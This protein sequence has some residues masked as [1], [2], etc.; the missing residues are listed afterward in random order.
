MAEQR[1]SGLLSQGTGLD[2]FINR[3]KQAY[4]QQGAL[5]AIAQAGGGLLDLLQLGGT[6]AVNEAL[7]ILYGPEEAKRRRLEI[8]Y[9]ER[10]ATAR[11]MADVV[12]RS[13]GRLPPV[14]RQ[15][16]QAMP[17]PAPTG[18]V[19][20][21]VEQRVAADRAERAELARLGQVVTAAAPIDRTDGKT[22][23]EVYMQEAA[24]LREAE[25]Q[26]E[27]AALKQKIDRDNATGTPNIMPYVLAGDNQAQNARERSFL[28]RMAQSGLLSTLQG[29]ARAERQYG[30]GPLAAF[31][32]SALDVQ[33]ARSAAEQE[34]AK[35]QSEGADRQAKILAEQIKK[36]GPSKLTG[37]I[38]KRLTSFRNNSEALNTINRYLTILTSG[39]TGGI[40]GKMDSG[41]D[42][43][44]S[45]VG[46]GSGSQASKAEAA[47]SLLLSTI[48]SLKQT[49]G[50][51]SKYDYE[52]IENYLKKPNSWFINN[53]KIANQLRN[54][55]PVIQRTLSQD[56]TLIRESGRDPAKYSGYDNIKLSTPGRTINE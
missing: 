48:S 24:R 22:G 9:L 27:A 54:L 13:E 39:Q 53:E 7:P 15:D 49:E 2:P 19:V 21:S 3:F 1:N 31:S 33:A 56:A 46:L 41:I 52:E 17:G 4:E 42:A 20:P 29:M 36:S 8:P 18:R 28:E 32:E 40:A 51:I 35:R 55:R 25:K 47:R 30:V 6:M 38:D 16:V 12:A 34:A 26:Q 43:L 50:Q 14:R 44:A 10:S 5:G 37:P 11:E 23:A 45:L